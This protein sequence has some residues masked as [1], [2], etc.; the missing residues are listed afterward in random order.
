MRDSLL[1]AFVNAGEAR[2]KLV[3][4]GVD[5]VAYVIHF[6][7]QAEEAGVYFVADGAQFVVELGFGDELGLGRWLSGE[8]FFDQDGHG[9]NSGEGKQPVFDRTSRR[10]RNL[11][12]KNRRQSAQW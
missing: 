10:T 6:F 4:A 2:L 1:G 3:E 5:G 11:R 12:Q 8:E 9:G 7:A